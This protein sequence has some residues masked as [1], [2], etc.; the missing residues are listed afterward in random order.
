VT[1]VVVVL[2]TDS[3]SLL[4]MSV[5]PVVVIV[6]FGE[7]TVMSPLVVTFTSTAISGVVEKFSGAVISVMGVTSVVVVFVGVVVVTAGDFD[8]VV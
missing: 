3:V 4:G 2:V 7:V 8:A 1:Y 5:V 6:A